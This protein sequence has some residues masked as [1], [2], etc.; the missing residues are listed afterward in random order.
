VQLK[1]G[2]RFTGNPVCAA[3]TPSGAVSGAGKDASDDGW[4]RCRSVPAGEARRHHR[5]ASGD[6]CIHE[7]ENRNITKRGN[8]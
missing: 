8:R 6:R 3:H 5:D 7:E 2:Y 4:K 1:R